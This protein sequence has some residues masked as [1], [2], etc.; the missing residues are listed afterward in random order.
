[1]ATVMAERVAGLGATA[2]SQACLHIHGRMPDNWNYASSDAVPMQADRLYRLSGWVRV[3]SA[4][5][6]T[7]MPFFKCEFVGADRSLALGR[8]I[9]DA[10]DAVHLGQW[11]QL[12]GELRA[13]A[14]T[15]ACWIALE[16][17]TSDPTQIDA[18][19]DDV[20][21]VP[22]E[23]LTA[24]SRYDLDP[25]PA[26]LEKVHGTHPRLYLHPQRVVEL[27]KAIQTTHAEL[28]AEVRALAD[29]AVQRGA[30]R[31]RA[32]DSYSGDEQLWQRDV[33]STM[34]F[35][36]LAHV[37]TGEKR[38][39]D[40]A[41]QWAQACCAYP[42]WGGGPFDG[43]DLATGHQLFGL[44]LVYDWCY[45]D[46][47]DTARQRIRETLVKR[48]SAMF[49]A[50][51]TGSTYWHRS[52]LQNHLWVNICGVAAA[53]F[54]LFDEVPEA[55]RWVGLALDKFRR[56][57]DVLGSDGAS[58]EGIGYWEYGAEYLLKFLH[59]ADELLGVD[60]YDR[61]WWRNTARYCQYLSLP[62]EAWASRNCL[63]DLADCP[64]THWYG[65]DYILRGL[66]QRYQDGHA[67]WLAEQV[68]KANVDA[69]G[70]R[71]LNL[72]WY[73]PSVQAAPPASL[74]TLHHFEDMG[75]VSA[76]TGWDGR[77][78]L[79][80]FK[81]GPFIG[82][83]ALNEFSYDPGGGHVH[84]DVG[85]FV[86]FAHGRWLIRDDGYQEK[87]TDQHNTLL[88]NGVGQLGEGHMWLN[89]TECLLAKSRPR[90]V[91]AHSSMELD[92]IV[93]DVTAAYPKRA[94][95]DRFVRHLLF[96]K[97][98][99]LILVDDIA[100]NAATDLELRLHTESTDCRQQEGGYLVTDK[101]VDLHVDLLTP[102]NVTLNAA[103]LPIRGSHGRGASLFTMRFA[104]HTARWQ[105]AVALTWGPTGSETKP[106]A[107]TRDGNT[108]TFT[109]AGRNLVF[110]W[111]D[112]PAVLLP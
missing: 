58:H 7:P 5:A 38:Y 36:A 52:Y 45:Q 85:H 57:M 54:A 30:P 19:I 28:W 29:R 27:R 105:N 68:D 23:Q 37:L 64:R 97:P 89:G 16:K 55:R 76:R 12:T 111:N 17:G 61:P 42:T 92:H 77:E 34:P 79:L 11:Q 91:R 98:D 26:A 80:V 69:P 104:K 83:K 15:V 107:L 75:I 25:P 108:W 21:L 9:T 74:P 33:G 100:V 96:V 6:G 13:P 51:A 44:A 31:Y 2:G 41:I 39:L 71:W 99:V 50:A 22:I 32:A 101:A 10:Y 66:A 94:G 1:M 87:W 90:V 67:Q 4:D 14:G 18:Y 73:D 102:D 35:L 62:C 82:H 88:V 110:E 106:I 49:Q 60:L 56:T 47:D 8:A 95:L 43:M 3:T 59:L 112:G 109:V 103:N 63:V 20:A 70:A 84:P 46:L 72:L 53:G 48:A 78:S 65:P 81:C 24:L 93:G 86:L 40:A